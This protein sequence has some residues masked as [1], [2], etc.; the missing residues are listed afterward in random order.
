MSVT[1]RSGTTRAQPGT[2]DDR[3]VLLEYQA[4]LDNA[5]VGIGFT[6][7]RRVQ[8]CN[9]RFAEIFGYDQQELTGQPGAIFYVDEAQYVE[10]GRRAG[11][12]LAA[13]A[14]FEDE[15]WM[16]RRDGSR[17]RCQ[18]RAK[19]FDPQDTDAGTIWIVEDITDARGRQQALDNTLTML[20]ALLENS[21]LAIV[22]TCNGIIQRCNSRFARMCAGKPAEALVG[23][24]S[25]NYFASDAEYARLGECAGPFL[26]RGEPYGGEVLLR[27]PDGSSFWTYSVGYVLDHADPERGTFWIIDD[28]S[29][30]K[31]AED[32]LREAVQTQ[33]AILENA[34]TGIALVT[35]RIIRRCNRRF[36]QIFDF[37]VGEM[38][39]QST[40]ILYADDA[41]FEFGT[42]GYAEVDAGLEHRR[43]QRLVRR[44]GTPFWCL[45]NGRAVEA[46]HPE[47]GYVWLFEDITARKEAEQ[48]TQELLR[49]QELILENAGVGIS[50]E[51]GRRIV[52]CNAH[53]CEMFG[54]T[55][56]ELIEDSSRLLV[57]T[58]QDR[59]GTGDRTRHQIDGK[60]HE[61]TEQYR[62]KSGET[63]TCRITGRALGERDGEPLWLWIYR[64]VT[65]EVD[66]R[67]ALEQ[68]RDELEQ[69]VAERTAEL[70]T[71]NTTLS[72]QLALIEQLIDA[73]P[74][75]VFYK[76]TSGRYMG[77][78]RAFEEYIGIERENLVGKSVFDISPPELA[79]KYDDA[80]RALL[81]SPGTQ[82]YDAMVRYADGSRH[83]VAFSKA[84]FYQADGSLAGIVG[85]M[86]D[87]TEHKRAEQA[88]RE[89]SERLRLYFDLPLIGMARLGLNDGWLEINDKLCEILGYGREEL[90]GM[91]WLDLV[92]PDDSAKETSRFSAALRG[93]DEGYTCD[94]RLLRRD[95]NPLDAHVILRCV[96]EDDGR[97]RYLVVMVQ[98]I[99]ARKRMEESL[100]LSA[101]VFEHAAEGVVIVDRNVRI[102][103]VNKTFTEITGYGE[104]ELLGQNPRVLQSGRTAPATYA[105]LWKSVAE[106]GLWRGELWN[107]R[108]DG[109]L[110][111]EL[112][113]ISAV[114][115]ANGEI[116]HYVGLVSDITTLKRSQEVLDYQAH[117]DP[118]T[119]LPNRLLFED[120]LQHSLNRAR[121]DKSQIA[122]MF[123]DLDRFKN[124]NDTL[125]HPVGDQV[126]RA[127]GQ[128]LQSSLRDSDTVARL[129]GDEFI[130]LLESIENEHDCS[131]IADKLLADLR[132]PVE[133]AGQEF[134]V[135]ASIGVS[136][137]PRDGE[138]VATLVRNADAAMYQAKE[139]GRNGYEIYHRELTSTVQ[140]RFVLEAE[141]RRALERGELSLHYQPQR[142]IYD[143]QLTG[144]EVLLR[145]R[146]PEHGPVSP[147]DFI[148]LAEE[149]G[150]IIEIGE[151]VLDTAC[152][153]LQRWIAA[154]LQ[155]PPLAV[156]ISEVQMR[157][158][159]L[160]NKV[161]AVLQ[162][163][164]L[165]A[166]YLE[167][168]ITE[169][170]ILHQSDERVSQLGRLRD[171]GVGL[172]I[173]DFGTG[174][175]SLSYLKRFPIDTLKID[176][177]FVRGLPGDADDAAITR[178]I[179]AMGRSLGLSIVAE[180]V[181]LP[182][183]QEFL[184]LAGCEFMQGYLYA[185][186]M[187]ADQ[188]EAE[189]LPGPAAEKATGD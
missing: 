105:E 29:E 24:A 173:D 116:T 73:M 121:R 45:M 125:G 56:E 114:R 180:G 79:E 185:R 69:R 23:E 63:L 140:K 50:L 98:D 132:R 189:L 177:S 141:L 111:A 8:H 91:A 9:P 48:R 168:E 42:A 58:E 31:A 37:G 47:R 117:H 165:P 161:E 172:A 101:T 26:A 150:L 155:P 169:G 6:C 93:D 144:A 49:E 128:R 162:R 65:H 178:A 12:L 30:T 74:H 158:G 35:D 51:Q 1:A 85:S 40:R 138:D 11:P 118:L 175:S 39:G 19:A 62:H 107:R 33:E 164:K 27:R 70:A 171:L 5:F 43:E 143:G 66:N 156:N 15:L 188:F 60:R 16:V 36:E 82:R 88:L 52:R 104:D 81:A 99:S 7:N 80:D 122:V 54:Y 106:Q 145:W 146:H 59:T 25:V 46:G 100:R 94:L 184:R 153:Q 115:D 103:A 160:L 75:P 142:R 34:L 182:A 154:G 166:G 55:C 3:T 14:V 133:A 57:E 21:P 110:F 167:L 71:A 95:G 84:V 89:Q 157:R 68:A 123:V 135:S 127:I 76:D 181:E 119:D 176:Q 113:T 96:R 124:I 152:D 77:C 174:Y 67:R 13:G 187:P 10:V 130:L 22:H 102:V 4:I 72:D 179:I 148:P 108:K 163:F 151:W 20:E 17:I 90:L 92:H 137:F 136:V 38:I 134:F 64:D 149:T 186:P 129:G 97:L 41:A 126:L 183:Q 28:I 32:R 44:D 147:A 87:L 159:N 139:Q 53:L 109:T 112:L 86:L 61:G 131:V 170:F 78:N 2:G 18:V 120:R 83:E